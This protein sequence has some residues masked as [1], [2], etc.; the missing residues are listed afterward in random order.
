MIHNG[1]S[2]YHFLCEVVYTCSPT[3]IFIIFFNSNIP[4][5]MLY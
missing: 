2:K 5:W 4:N 1:I 3:S